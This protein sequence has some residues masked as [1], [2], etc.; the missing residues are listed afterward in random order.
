MSIQESLGTHQVWIAGSV[1]LVFTV[2]AR[3]LRGVNF[4]GALAGAVIC[5]VIYVSAG[6]PAVAILVLVFA[7]TW[8]STRFGSTHK[9]QLGSAED[10]HGRNAAQVLAN[11]GVAGICAMASGA[12]GRS[13]FV[14]GMV[15]SLAEAAGDTVSS[16]L[17][18]ACSEKARLITTWQAVA[19][20][21]SGGVS[22]VG[23]ACGVA[24]VVLISLAAAGM[25]L[26]PG[27]WLAVSSLAA[28]V[29]MIVDSILGATLEKKK[30]LDNNR[31]NFL[32]TLAAALIAMV[33]A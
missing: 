20:G 8:I 30:L 4:S 17:G 22:I 7:L 29:G 10:R 28:T 3:A 24:T 21:T 19:A 31:V 25:G 11:L 26:L 23:S 5:F 16:E 32:S 18:R 6:P 9:R 14:L 15:G 33:L 27:K 2:L 12:T 13:I 1:T